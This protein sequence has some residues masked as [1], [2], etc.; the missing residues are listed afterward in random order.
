MTIEQLKTR[1]S[2]ELRAVIPNAVIQINPLSKNAGDLGVSV[3]AVEHGDVRTVKDI[4]LNLDGELCIGTEFSLT[5]MVR[6]MD[7]TRKYYPQ[8]LPV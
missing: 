8:F 4:I 2:A 3:F 6:D 7:T 1:V 5:P